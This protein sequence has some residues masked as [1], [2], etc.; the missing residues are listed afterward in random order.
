MHTK[1]CNEDNCEFF[2]V[3]RFISGKWKILIIHKLSEHARR[4]SDLERCIGHI[5]KATL[6]KQL[7]ELEQHQL[8]NRNV[9]STNPFQVEYELTEW[10]RKFLPILDSLED[11]ALTQ[12]SR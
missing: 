8:I 10:G 6:S 12:P 4:F 3:A 1:I 11:W 7:K 9:I 2:S 5:N